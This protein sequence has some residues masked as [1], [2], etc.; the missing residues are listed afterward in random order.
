MIHKLCDKC[1]DQTNVCL[2]SIPRTFVQNIEKTVQLV[3]VNLFLG[4]Q[5]GIE[6]PF[7]AKQDVINLRVDGFFSAP[8]GLK[9]QGL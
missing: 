5:L 2:E 9:I 3:I 1:K 6:K 8:F 7:P 4:L